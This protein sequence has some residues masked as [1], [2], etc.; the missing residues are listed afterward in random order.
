MLE[1][2]RRGQDPG[3]QLGPGRKEESKDGPPVVSEL[4]VRIKHMQTKKHR[5]KCHALQC[6]RAKKKNKTVGTR[7]IP[8]VGGCKTFTKPLHFMVIT[9]EQNL[10]V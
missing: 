5:H 1:V 3:F 6:N 4:H 8:R 2:P 7:F 10:I 9:R